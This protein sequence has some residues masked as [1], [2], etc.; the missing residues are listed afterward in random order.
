MI[1]REIN[2]C[3]KLKQSVMKSEWH[4]IINGR[5]YYIHRFVLINFICN[6][7]DLQITVSTLYLDKH[8]YI[9]KRWFTNLW[10]RLDDGGQSTSCN[11]QKYSKG[12]G[13][14]QIKDNLQVC[15]QDLM[16]E[17]RVPLVSCR[18]LK[19]RGGE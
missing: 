2:H 5:Y 19:G 14:E 4:I 18:N 16:M 12:G 17:V 3:Q 10:S 13:G 9:L 6:V 7:L 8:H 15:G 1:T 11:L